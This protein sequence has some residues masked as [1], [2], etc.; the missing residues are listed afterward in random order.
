LIE[1][2]DIAMSV[3]E[4]DGFSTIEISEGS[5]ENFEEFYY[6]NGV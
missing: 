6:Q 5:I 1:G 2:T 3:K 4:N